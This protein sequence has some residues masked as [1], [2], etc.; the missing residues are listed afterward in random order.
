MKLRKKKRNRRKKLKKGK[1][2]RRK[3][4]NR[5][6]KRKRPMPNKIDKRYNLRKKKSTSKTWLEA[7]ISSFIEF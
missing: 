2:L 1:K 4:I 5:L 3:K 7:W 6:K